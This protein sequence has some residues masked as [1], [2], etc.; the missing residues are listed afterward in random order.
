MSFTDNEIRDTTASLLK[1]A[2]RVHSAEH[3][4]SLP[5]LESHSSS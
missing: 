2:P 5:G 3:Q 1:E 4:V